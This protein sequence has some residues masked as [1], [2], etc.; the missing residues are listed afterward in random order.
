VPGFG[1]CFVD[2]LLGEGRVSAD[3]FWHLHPDW[4]LDERAG[5][6][7][8]GSHGRMVGLASSAALTAVRDPQF[9]VHA[10]VYGRIVNAPCLTAALPAEAPCSLLTFATREPSLTR[11]LTVEPLA[12]AHRASE[13]WHTSAFVIRSAEFTAFL[14]ASVERDGVPSGDSGPSEFWGVPE[15]TTDA[16]VA[17]TISG[18]DRTSASVVVHGTSVHERSTVASSVH[19]RAGRTALVP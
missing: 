15:V 1:W 3:A 2:H 4:E 11:E 16:R 19:Q 9:A 8:L 14:L 7:I 10:P 12:V 13:R 5:A 17:L 18:A 6:W